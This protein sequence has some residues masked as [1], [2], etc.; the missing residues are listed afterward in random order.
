MRPAQAK[1]QRASVSLF[2]G[3]DTEV[4]RSALKTKGHSSILA[5]RTPWTAAYQAPPSMGFS[6]HAWGRVWDEG[7]WGPGWWAPHVD[8]G[9]GPG[10]GTW[11]ATRGRRSGSPTR[12]AAESQSVSPARRMLLSLLCARLI[13]CAFLHFSR[14]SHS[15]G[16]MSCSPCPPL[17]DQEAE[18]EV[19]PDWPPAAACPPEF[20]I[21]VCWAWPQDLC[22]PASSLGQQRRRGTSPTRMRARTGRPRSRR[23]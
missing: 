2:P 14:P 13:S 3:G 18:L 23:T 20:S 9:P 7:A 19:H 4:H 22:S 12:G 11:A 1:L 16:W 8:Q 15:V 10:R 6:R 17:M 21:W 5:W